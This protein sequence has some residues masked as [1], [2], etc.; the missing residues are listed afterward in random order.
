MTDRRLV[1]DQTLVTCEIPGQI[2][3][4]HADLRAR[5]MGPRDRQLLL[6]EDVTIL[7]TSQ[8]HSY[9]RAEKDGYVGFVL[10]DSIGTP[11]QPTHKVIRAATHTYTSPS[12]KSA[13]LIAL[14]FGAGLSAISETDDFI[15][16]IHGYIP[17]QTIAKWPAPVMNPVTTARLFL[18]TPYLWGGNTRAGIDCSGLV[19]TALLSA[20]QA[21]PG[22]SDQQKTQ[23]G[24]LVSDDTY[25]PGDLIFWNGHVALVT[26]PTEMIHANSFHMSVVEEPIVTAI[27]RIAKTG[28]DHITA[29]K[30][31]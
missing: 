2:S 25:H 20:G 8:Q 1:P 27:D 11:T 4:A 12:I 29:H 15:E 23:L 19:Q 26:T 28:G 18:G 31:L 5:P 10:S 30:R 22:D 13:D 17:K 21:C 9:V 14:S 3:V 7:G 24:Q 16:T 6:G